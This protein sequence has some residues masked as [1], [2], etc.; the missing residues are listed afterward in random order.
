MKLSSNTTNLLTVVIVLLLVYFLYKNQNNTVHNEGSLNDSE[1][2]VNS[3]INVEVESDSDEDSDEE[4]ESK[5]SNDNDG[6]IVNNYSNSQ[7]GNTEGDWMNQFDE[8]NNITVQEGD[9]SF[10]ANSNDQGLATFESTGNTSC[11]A[12]ENCDVDDLF[13]LE[14]ATPQEKKD[15]WFETNTIEVSNGNLISAISLQ[16]IDT[17]PKTTKSGD[18]RAAPLC[19]KFTVSPWLQ[20]TYEADTNLKP[21]M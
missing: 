16:G 2:N 21:L 12:G 5:D 10:V 11:N 13:N 7:R 6:A 19:P 14:N 3:T 9:G 18:L 17:H 20:S 8:N 15:D 4:V 1:T